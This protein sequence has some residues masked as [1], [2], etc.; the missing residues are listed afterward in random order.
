MAITLA[1]PKN[2]SSAV[3]VPDGILDH[4]SQA[5]AAGGDAFHIAHL[6]RQASRLSCARNSTTLTDA[7][8]VHAT[9][10]VRMTLAGS[11]LCH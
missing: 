9:I 11:R 1:P 5:R 7:T 4:Q 3:T 10:P 2:E 6:Q 8:S